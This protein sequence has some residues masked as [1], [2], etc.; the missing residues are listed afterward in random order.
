[1]P[2]GMN[3]IMGLVRSGQLGAATD[4]IRERLSGE[5]PEAGTV[6]G[7]T[8]AAA[9]PRRADASEAPRRASATPLRANPSPGIRPA[10][11]ARRRP[12]APELPDGARVERRTAAVP[13]GLSY[14]LYVPSTVVRP[15][16]LVVMLHGCT[17]DP[18]DFALGTGMDAA[19]ELRGALVAYPRQEASANPN[20]CW[21]WFDPRHQ[22]RGGEA[23]ALAAIVRDVI[24]RDGADPA[25]VF[26]AGLSAGGAMAANLGAAYPDLFAGVGIHSGLAAGAARDMPGAFGAMRSGGGAEPL[27]VRAIVFHGDADATVAPVNAERIAAA[28]RGGARARA[29]TARLGGRDVRVTRLPAAPGAAEM[30]LWQVKGLGHAWSGGSPAGSYAD[31]AGPDASAE[32][33][34]FF[35]GEPAS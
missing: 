27:P 1:M 9:A 3:E 11:K 14:R 10:A 18:D 25:R 6:V 22:G 12:P 24:G 20:R 34:R 13:G 26:V 33:L 29:R 7:R 2:D 32:M 35:L 21:N 28:G 8:A 4:A 15:A 17:Q 19:A 16:P 5:R 31:A 23:A 30:E